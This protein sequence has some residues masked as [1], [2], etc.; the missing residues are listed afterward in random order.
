MM[1]A[2]NKRYSYLRVMAIQIDVHSTWENWT[3]ST[4]P[5]KKRASI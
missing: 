1:T 2:I 4:A 3:D 5:E